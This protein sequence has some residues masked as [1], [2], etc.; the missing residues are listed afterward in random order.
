[1]VC[2]SCVCAQAIRGSRSPQRAEDVH[3]RRHEEAYRQ[4]QQRELARERS[5]VPGH[6]ESLRARPVPAGKGMTRA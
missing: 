3:I 5:L 2:V 1:M 4:G 6:I